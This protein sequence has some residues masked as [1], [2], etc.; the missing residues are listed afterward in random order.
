MD[1]KEC[2]ELLQA[3]EIRPTVNRILTIRALHGAGRPMSL[4]ELEYKLLTVDKSGIFRALTLFREHHLVHV[5][6]DGDGGV[7]YELCM[8]HSG[9]DDDDVHVHFYCEHCHRTLCLDD[10]PIPPVKLPAG[11]RQLSANYVVKGICSDCSR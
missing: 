10:V 8:S 5:I 7:K 1:E 9:D 11:Y 3:H 4:S 2:S 6:E